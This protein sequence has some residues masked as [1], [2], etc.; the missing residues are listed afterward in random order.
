MTTYFLNGP[1]NGTMGAPSKNF[2]L[3]CRAY[4]PSPVTLQ[5]YD[6]V[7]MG[8]FWSVT[9][10]YEFNLLVNFTYTAKEA[11]EYQIFCTNNAGWIDAPAL[12]YTITAPQDQKQ[13]ASS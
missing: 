13:A 7:N 4:I 8:S 10:N 2:T 12:I 3:D 9:T 11:R 5:C 1:T 6:G